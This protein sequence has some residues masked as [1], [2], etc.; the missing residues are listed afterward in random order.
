M[1]RRIFG[2]LSQKVEQFITID[3]SSSESSSF[4]VDMQYAC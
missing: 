2:L 4:Q 1:L 3:V